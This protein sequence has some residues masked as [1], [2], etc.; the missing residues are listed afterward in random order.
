MGSISSLASGNEYNSTKNQT[1]PSRYCGYVE[2]NQDINQVQ[3]YLTTILTFIISGFG[4][5]GNG[6]VICL[7]LFYIKRNHFTTY[8][9]NL[10]VADLGVVTGLLSIN[11]YWLVSR[12]PIVKYEDP[13]KSIFR[14]F[15]LVMYCTSQFLLTV[16]SIDRCASIFFPIW[17]RY[18]QPQKFSIIVCAVIWILITPLFP[19]HISLYL[20]LR[21]CEIW[22]YLFLMNA[23]LFTPGMTVTTVAI[24]IKVCLISPQYKRG[25][26]LIA[27]LLALL[28]FL[29]FALPM[30]IIQYLSFKVPNFDHSYFYEYGYIC[31][32]INSS[33]NPYIYFF[34]GR[35]KG[36]Q[37]RKKIHK[38]LQ[39]I[40]KEEDSR[41]L[42]NPSSN[43]TYNASIKSAIA[44]V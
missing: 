20:H 11:A 36:G 37:N 2:G 10:S 44:T 29:L 7:L 22:F 32:A 3:M 8:I 27:I 5:V 21:Y 14:T 28:F 42:E 17:Y 23:V 12:L 30:N 25:K 4:F 33:V 24:L 26:I 16:I 38:I 15:F 39:N 31:A 13:L 1:N 18:H 9:L 34:I 43:S 41:A 19:A 35:G 6:T 40:F